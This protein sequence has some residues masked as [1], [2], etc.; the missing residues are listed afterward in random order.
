[1]CFTGDRH[2]GEQSG[3]E[4]SAMRGFPLLEPGHLIRAISGQCT[5][6]APLVR[7]AR[8]LS[9][10]HAALIRFV[11]DPGVRQGSAESERARAEISLIVSEID[12][13]AACHVP[14]AG[15]A[16][17]HTHSLGEVISHVA[18]VYA[19]AW[20]TVLHSANAEKRHRAWFHLS[21]AREGYEAMVNEIRARR[22]QLPLGWTGI[23]ETI[24]DARAGPVAL[25][26]YIRGDPVN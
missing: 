11:T 16:R 21:E 14:R 17:K 1:M 4:S 25:T 3:T 22:L 13:W 19:D 23:R 26:A 8:E 18:K 10:I 20:W 2:A 15:C 5:G 9:D 24:S 7:W 12:A 6:S